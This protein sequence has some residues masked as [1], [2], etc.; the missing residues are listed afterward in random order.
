[1][2]S[3]ASEGLEGLRSVAA[4]V[5]RLEAKVDRVGRV[6]E[7]LSTRPLRPDCGESDSE[8]STFEWEDVAR[9]AK[10][11]GDSSRSLLGK[12]SASRPRLDPAQQGRQ[13]GQLRAE[14]EYA[15]PLPVAVAQPE[16]VVG[17][18]HG[19]NHR[20]ERI[21]VAVGTNLSDLRGAAKAGDDD[22]DRKRLKEKLKA[23][24]ES[25]AKGRHG[26]HRN[27]NATRTDWLEY[28]FGICKP[29]RRVGKLGS[30]SKSSCK[31]I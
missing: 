4:T 3:D 5:Q 8:V 11:G 24:L 12:R 23:A 22:E 17:M 29:D 25:E 27:V 13:I 15:R 31:H 14:P 6:V 16:A 10:G 18:L 26:V 7:S 21:A 9:R 1:M 28:I 19:M 2:Y 20:L 30:R